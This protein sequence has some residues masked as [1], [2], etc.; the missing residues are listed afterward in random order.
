[1]PFIKI[2]VTDAEGNEKFISTYPRSGGVRLLLITP[3]GEGGFCHLNVECYSHDAS[4]L[5]VGAVKGYIGAVKNG[6]SRYLDY[7]VGMGELHQYSGVEITQAILYPND[8]RCRRTST[9]IM[10]GSTPHILTI[11]SR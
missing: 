10:L 8:V 3:R 6:D 2:S 7:E 4:S 9:R 1:M 5:V 11:K